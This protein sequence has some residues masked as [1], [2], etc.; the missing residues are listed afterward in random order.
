MTAP[1]DYGS[2]GRKL[3]PDSE[4]PRYQTRAEAVLFSMT[5]ITASD[6]AERGQ[7][8]EY[9]SALYA[10]MDALYL[11]DKSAGKSSESVGGYSVAYDKSRATEAAVYDAARPYLLSTGLLYRGC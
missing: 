10:I 8:W 7:D 2:S 4:C 11:D 1:A 9:A 6:A 5:G 3:I